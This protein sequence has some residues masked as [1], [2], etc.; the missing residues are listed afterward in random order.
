M[1]TLVDDTLALGWQDT[2]TGTADLESLSLP[3]LWEMI[4]EN[5][6]FESGWDKCRF[7]CALPD[8]ALVY[9]NLNVLAQVFENLVRN[10]IRH[11][12][13]QG[14]V[15]LLGQ[16]GRGSL[17]PAGSGSGAGGAGRQT[18]PNLCALCASGRCPG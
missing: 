16:W 17:A 7:P 10:A 4:V 9:G 12:P 8:D 15:Q 14:T 13:E 6:A 3:V 5:A 1:R 18:R 11:S 2:D